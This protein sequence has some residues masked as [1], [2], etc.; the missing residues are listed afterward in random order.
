MKST[1]QH[2]TQNNTSTSCAG[3]RNKTSSFASSK[4]AGVKGKDWHVLGFMENGD[5]TSFTLVIYRRCCLLVFCKS[6]CLE[7]VGKFV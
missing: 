2:I 1:R 3:K 5:S 6:N 4:L 7:I